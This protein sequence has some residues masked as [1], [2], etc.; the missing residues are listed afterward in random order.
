MNAV[1]STRFSWLHILTV[2]I[3]VI[4]MGSFNTNANPYITGDGLSITFDGS[5]RA[6]DLTMDTYDVTFS[7]GETGGFFIRDN[8]ID[9]GTGL[10]HGVSL[11]DNLLQ[12]PG[13]QDQGVECLTS[14]W[15]DTTPPDPDTSLFE[16]FE[17]PPDSGE[18]VAWAEIDEYPPT[19]KAS[20]A[21]LSQVVNLSSIITTTNDLYYLMFEMATESGWRPH[22]HPDGYDRERHGKHKIFARVEWFGP[23]P[24]PLPAPQPEPALTALATSTIDCYETTVL[25][26]GGGEAT[27][28]TRF[29]LRTH[30]PLQP[31]E[32]TRVR[33]SLWVQGFL[34]NDGTGANDNY[35][36]FDNVYFFKA[37]DVVQVSGYGS[38]GNFDPLPG[39]TALSMWVDIT[40]VDVPGGPHYILFDGAVQNDDT[41]PTRNPRAIDLGFALPI[42][43]AELGQNVTW[44]D[45]ARNSTEIS[46]SGPT[47]WVPYRFTGPVDQ[48]AAT[49]LLM[50]SEPGGD[51][52]EFSA[53]AANNQISAY[54]FSAI[55]IK[56]GSDGPYG[57]SFGEQLWDTD[58]QA[59]ADPQV[60][61]FGYHIEQPTSPFI[62]RYYVEFNLGLLKPSVGN[63]AA[64]FSFILFRSDNPASPEESSFR[65]GAEKYQTTFFPFAFTR[66]MVLPQ[67]DDW[68]FGGGGLNPE[69]NEEEDNWWQT[70]FT[71]D[72]NDFGLRYA[73]K[74]TEADL[75]ECLTYGIA[76]DVRVLIYD[77][78]WTADFEHEDTTADNANT[79]T[80]LQDEA[81][82]LPGSSLY[83]VNYEHRLKQ[84]NVNGGIS[85]LFSRGLGDSEDKYTFPVLIADLDNPQVEIIDTLTA[86]YTNAYST[87]SAQHDNP[88][89]LAGVLYDNVFN[90]ISDANHLDQTE[91]RLVGYR[92][93]G[94]APTYS[95]NNFM[96]AI[97][98]LIPNAR[99]LDTVNT[100]L[101]TIDGNQSL[102]WGE[103]VTA[104]GPTTEELLTGNIS[105]YDFGG[106]KYGLMKFGV[107]GFESNAA[108]AFNSS[109]ESLSFMRTMARDKSMTRPLME[110][111]CLVSPCPGTLNGIL[112]NF[113]DLGLVNDFFDV[114]QLRIHLVNEATWM[115]LAW[116][117]HPEITNYLP[118]WG[119][120]PGNQEAQYYDFVDTHLRPLFNHRDPYDPRIGYTH[121]F[122]E[123][124][125]AG[126]DPVT[127][128][129]IDL[130]NS[131]QD[132]SELYWERFGGYNGDPG[133]SNLTYVTV[134]NNKWL[135]FTLVE[136]FENKSPD[137][138]KLKEIKDEQQL[139]DLNLL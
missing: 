16:E 84:L 36:W 96:P 62:G 51:L 119:P 75:I 15:T 60:A 22:D 133:P 18:F 12:C 116:G 137:L 17:T 58:T 77:R 139:I 97:P 86:R 117:F 65:D 91:A 70:G 105:Q 57:V 45:D 135:Q 32:A 127:N 67:D 109:E 122:D 93:V 49:K 76:R 126:W 81:Y 111:P 7:S 33:I 95:F 9:P 103:G 78:P 89:G 128:V 104:S 71:N 94:G 48:R 55:D 131:N 90:D 59:P 79:Y 24:D 68:L 25:D 82:V 26:P 42:L 125:L 2:M 92:N 30:R 21:V 37:P 4:F 74:G 40:E 115:T 27:G 8:T 53:R 11:A 136:L 35:V 19:N 5:G 63:A 66:P 85:D 29:C 46:A 3:T 47:N 98:Q 124:H 107:A 123:L 83:A 106:T 44:W 114:D 23:T 118:W 130:E 28:M 87:I 102:K 101:D 72:P 31:A 80:K 50:L 120:E 132:I 6:T 56:N 41:D 10:P 64:P 138:P 69:W 100:Q 52:E 1:K 54:P 61:H 13:F 73:R 110:F 134:L 14:Y 39:L 20:W 113:K 88:E 34:P 108:T 99:F 38:G 121:I 129:E 43:D 112:M